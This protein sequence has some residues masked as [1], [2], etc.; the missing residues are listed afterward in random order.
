MPHRSRKLRET[1]TV[2]IKQRLTALR[3]THT[4]QAR[5]YGYSR[6]HF[7]NVVNGHYPATKRFFNFMESIGVPPH[8]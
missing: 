7:S 5:Q 4:R 1:E 6:P 8:P 3:T 2:A